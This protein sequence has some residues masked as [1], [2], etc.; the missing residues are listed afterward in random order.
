[1]D[2]LQS[3]TVV[4][5]GASS[6]IGLAVAQQA[7]QAGARVVMASRSIDK[8]RQA[9]SHVV[10]APD[11]VAL[12]ML[13]PGA[14]RRALSALGTIDHLVLTAVADENQRRGRVTAL[15]DEQFERSMDKFRGF[16]NVV[17]AAALSMA[18]RGSITLTSGDSAFKPPREGM[19]V[20]AGVNAAVASFGK[21][22]ARELSPV[23][24]NV[25]SPGVVDTPVWNA[26][27]RTRIKAWAESAE[28]PAQRFGQAD[29]IA[30][31]MIFLMTNPYVIGEMLFV[32]GGLVVT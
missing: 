18:E 25:V 10:G 21:A 12:D 15:T 24:V 20:L 23:R 13:D 1:M 29:D 28:L 7:A 6:G 9:A 2:T 26:E 5:I 4:V 27:Q 16:F 22:L 14:V 32:D 31:A 17:R 11:L 30:H 19:S 8:L 3:K